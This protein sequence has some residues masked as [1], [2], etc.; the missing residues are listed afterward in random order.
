VEFAPSLGQGVAAAVR[1]EDTDLEAA[2]S[3]AIANIV[4][5]DEYEALSVRHLGTNV[6]PK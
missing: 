2:L 3:E 4:V 6:A 1:L 5:S